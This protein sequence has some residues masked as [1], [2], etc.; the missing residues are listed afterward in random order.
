MTGERFEEFLA[1]FFAARGYNVK[2]TPRTGDY[3]VDLVLQKSREII[4][5]QAKCWKGNVGVGAIQEVHAGKAHYG[6]NK[7]MVVTNSHFTDAAR[8]LARSTSVNLWDREELRKQI[9]VAGGQSAKKRVPKAA[10]TPAR[11]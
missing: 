2:T 8:K 3:G 6:A 11:H 5:V 9:L 4:V 7:A 1:H 10:G